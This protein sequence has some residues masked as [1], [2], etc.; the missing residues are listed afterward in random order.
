MVFLGLIS[1]V[2]Q[3]WDLQ[4]D[5][6]KLRQW[7]QGR[8]EATPVMFAMVSGLELGGLWLYLQRKLLKTVIS[9]G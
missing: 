3:T 8:E 2:L 9:E 4:A 1:G 5:A 7:A 6:E